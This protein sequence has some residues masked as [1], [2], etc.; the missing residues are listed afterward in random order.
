MEYGHLVSSSSQK[1]QTPSLVRSSS[2]AE[3]RVCAVRPVE[4]QGGQGWVGNMSSRVIEACL[5]FERSS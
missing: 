4:A 3:K 2:N 5:V 1:Q